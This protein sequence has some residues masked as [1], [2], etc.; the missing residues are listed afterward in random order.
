MKITKEMKEAL[1]ETYMPLFNPF[2]PYRVLYLAT[3]D[4]E[5]NPNITVISFAKAVD[6]KIVIPDIAL[7]KSRLNIEENPDVSLIVALY[8][9]YQPL[10][11]FGTRILHAITKRLVT[12]DISLFGRIKLRIL[13]ALYKIFKRFIPRVKYK[14]SLKSD[15]KCFEFIGKA[16]IVR[17]GKIYDNMNKFMKILFGKNFELN[18]IVEIEVEEIKERGLSN[19]AS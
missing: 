4:K 19:H 6:N 10:G 1:E 2:I 13:L 12:I 8:R 18:G 15:A 7:L 9:D 16:K 17:Y 5:G 3:C 11:G 14:V